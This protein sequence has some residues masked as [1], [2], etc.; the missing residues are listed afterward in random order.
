MIQCHTYH[1]IH[2]P[3]HHSSVQLDDL[4]N[5]IEFLEAD[6]IGAYLGCCVKTLLNT[7]DETSDLVSQLIVITACNQSQMCHRLNLQ[8]TAGTAQDSRIS[9]HQTHR[10]A[11]KYSNALTGLE[12]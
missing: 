1:C 8:H 9:G 11:T 7:I 5:R 4:L 6:C 12:P 2:R 10:A 3:I